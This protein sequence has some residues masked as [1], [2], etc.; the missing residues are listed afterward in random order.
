MV[1][2]QSM[3]PWMI[4][5]VDQLLAGQAFVMVCCAILSYV[6]FESEPKFPSTVAEA[7]RRRQHQN[8]QGH[9]RGRAIDSM[10]TIRQE[11][12]QLFKDTQYLLLL[13]SFGIQYAVNNGMPFVFFARSRSLLDCLDRFLSFLF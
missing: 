4:R 11:I 7:I 2:G 12:C 8:E 5:R 1:I 10:A 13:V 3:S 6:Y 9:L